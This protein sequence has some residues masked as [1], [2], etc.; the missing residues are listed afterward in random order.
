MQNF[1]LTLSFFILFIF[2]AAQGIASESQPAK[3]GE[4][5]DPSE[6]SENS[7]DKLTEKLG[8]SSNP[9]AVNISVGSGR[10]QKFFM[11]KAGAKND[12]GIKLG[13]MWLSDIDV[14]MSGGVKPG[15]WSANSLL[16]LDLHIDA[17]KLL[18]WKGASFG[19]EF[20]QFNGSNTNADAGTVQGYNSLPG[21]HPLNRSELYQLW[22]RQELWDDKLVFRLGKTVP[23]YHFGNILK[24]T[25]NSND[26]TN[27]P[28]VTSVIYTPIFVNPTMLG[29]LPGY[30]NSVYGAVLTLAPV[31][32]FYFNAGVFDG[33]MAR[34]KQTGINVLPE[35]NGY[36]FAIGEMGVSWLLGQEEKPGNVAVGAWHQT[37]ELERSGVS[38][39]GV[40]GFYLFGSQR[41]WYKDP[42][43]DNGGLSFFYQFGVNNS[44]LISATHYIGGGLT[45]FQLVPH[46]PL[47]SMGVGVAFSWLNDALLPRSN[48]FMFQAYYQAHIIYDLYLQPVITYIP[49]PGASATAKGAVASSVRMMFFF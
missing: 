35:F 3:G 1:F 38:Q 43:K 37:G 34:G 30:Y 40:S 31:K 32:Q 12:H 26:K 23:T 10:A 8:I 20:L 15:A 13:G 5:P 41:L 24:P 47:D 42:G 11:E 44:K 22:Y 2:F 25:S 6:Q 36:Y 39:N 16:I 4:E 45:A 18:H 28:S 19:A 17:E 9:G 49:N 48:E 14:L 46:R 7:S 27:I 33:N 21:E 29:V